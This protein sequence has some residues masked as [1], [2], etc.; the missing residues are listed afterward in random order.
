M[1]QLMMGPNWT[2]VLGL[3]KKLETLGVLQLL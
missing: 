3:L 1:T 2:M